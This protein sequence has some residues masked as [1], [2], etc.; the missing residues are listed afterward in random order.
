[1]I[2]IPIGILCGLAG[3]GITFSFMNTMIEGALW[4]SEKLRLIVTPLLLLI[5]CLVS[6]LTIFVSA[7][8]P[9]VKA[10]RVSPMDA[11]RQTTD[12]KL[13][14]KAVK[15]SKIIRKL[16]GIEAEIGLKNLKG[17][18][19]DIMLFFFAC[20]Q[21]RFVFDDIVFHDWPDTI[22]GIVAGRHQLRY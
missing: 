1:M 17:T 15:T 18:N 16:F 22:S 20:H 2:S 10:S 9:A 13:T 7:Y 3:I 8:L 12:V 21:H 4:T 11:I 14:A 5:T 19:E 6:M